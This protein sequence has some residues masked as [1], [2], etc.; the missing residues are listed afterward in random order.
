MRE[1]MAPFC[2]NYKVPALIDN[3]LKVWDSLAICE[4]INEGYLDNSAWPKQPQQ[5]AQARAISAEMHAGFTHL[6]NEMPMNCR[7]TPSAITLS[8]GAQ[9][10]IK[11]I[12][13]IWQ[14]C[15]STIELNTS[16]D[17]DNQFLFG[18]FS[19]ADAMYLPVISRFNSYQ[20]EVPANIQ[21]Y[22]DMMLNLP[23]Y[24]LWLQASIAEVEI[25]AMGKI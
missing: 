15:L 14:Q 18:E 13:E 8:E 25:M 20:I 3:E 5:R 9:N 4:Y 24:K 6:R 11:R 1:Q 7:R 12:I 23:G 17:P 16:G 21:K 22:M 19:I 10:D 2:P